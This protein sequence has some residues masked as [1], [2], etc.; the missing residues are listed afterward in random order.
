MKKISLL[1]GALLV[2]FTASLKAST[3]DLFAYNEQVV[4]AKMADLNELEK[5][6]KQNEGITLSELKEK[7]LATLNLD[8]VKSD[9]VLGGLMTMEPPLGVPSFVWGCVLGWVG[10]L[11]VYLITEDKEETKK[12]LYGCLVQGGVGVVFYVFYIVLWAAI[13][14]SA[15]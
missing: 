1:F 8:N 12:A 5:V 10:I 6:V 7:K 11:V 4:S 13:F 2:F 14:T 9:V 3:A 15:Y